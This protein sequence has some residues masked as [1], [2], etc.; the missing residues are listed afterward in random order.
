MIILAMGKWK[1]L[2]C[3]VILLSFL[4]ME[5]T[6]KTVL[7]TWISSFFVYYLVLPTL[8]WATVWLLKLIIVEPS[9]NFGW[10]NWVVGLLILFP[11]LAISIWSLVTLYK[12]GKG[13]PFPT[14]ATVRL[15]T[16]GPYTHSRNPMVVSMFSVYWA[17]GIL[18]GSLTFIILTSFFFLVM[19]VVITLFEEKDLERKFGREYLLY[20]QRTLFMIPRI[21]SLAKQQDS[22]SL[23]T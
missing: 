17:V 8:L 7:A 14:V 2:Q 22:G 6:G 13:T 4:K 18:I 1:P 21:K 11:N 9:I 10:V 3:T 19:I 23:D 16:T 15:V 20:R 5:H 12:E